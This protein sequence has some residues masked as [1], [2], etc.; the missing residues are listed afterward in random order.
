[1]RGLV[2]MVNDAGYHY[3]VYRNLD[4]AARALLD[5]N[6]SAPLLRQLAQDIGYDD[7][8]I[9]GNP[10]SYY[11]DGLY[12]AVA[13]T[14]YPQLFD[15][16][17]TPAVRRVQLHAAEKAL[18]SN[19]FAPFTAAEWVQMNTYTEAY[20]GCL[21]WPAPVH[22]DPPVVK[23]LPLLDAPVPVLVLN[24]SIDSLTPPLGGAHVA[25]Q[26]GPSARFVEVP[27]MVHLVGLYD[28]YGCGSSIIQ[29][30]VAHP[31]RL[32]TLD[33]S[34]TRTVPEVRAIGSYPVRTTDVVGAAEATV[35]DAVQ[36]WSYI[37]G[38]TDRGLRGGSLRAALAAS[39]D[40]VTH[41]TLL[42]DR[43]AANVAVSGHVTIAADGLGVSAW[44]TAT[45][46]GG[47]S[48]RLHIVWDGG[49]P[50]ALATVTGPG[51]QRVVPAP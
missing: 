1:M 34:C 32:A 48:E 37:S 15:M 41:E 8:D 33:T 9:V 3:G 7:G 30:F 12:L 50:H 2:D 11:S 6:D 10:A 35:G 46:D 22:H 43:F 42:A 21:D 20:T 39:A 31:D 49:R 47:R 51:L 24:G 16:S 13:C 23:A 38:S 19:T 27:N 26:L 44:V 28:P 40:G 25:E 5:H 18:P 36:R 4:A 14:D 45:L 29:A 17:A